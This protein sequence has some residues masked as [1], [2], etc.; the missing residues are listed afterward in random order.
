[1]F[2]MV[3]EFELEGET[4]ELVKLLKVTGL[5]QTGGEAKVVTGEG[6][7]KVDGTVETRKKK[8]IGRGQIVAYNETLIKVV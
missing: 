6:L 3:K 4:I 7:V 2:P 8:K 5:C 1:M